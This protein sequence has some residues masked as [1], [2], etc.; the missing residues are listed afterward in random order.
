MTLTAFVTM[1]GLTLSMTTTNPQTSARS[2]SEWKEA[3]VCVSQIVEFADP[4]EVREVVGTVTN[5]GGGQ[6]PETAAV[7]IELRHQKDRSIRYIARAEIPSGRFKLKNV[8]EGKY[9]FRVSAR[10]EGW[11][12]VQGWIVVS[13]HSP[14]TARVDLEVLLG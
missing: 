6:W 7:V 10:P 13:R 12:C 11:T 1:V 9:R 2:D 4:F 3:T 5:E 8:R 14:K